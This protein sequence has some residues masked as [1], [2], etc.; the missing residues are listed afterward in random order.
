M[1]RASRSLISCSSKA[2]NNRC[3][4]QPSVSDCAHRSPANRLMVG[5]RKSV[6][7]IPR[8][9]EVVVTVVVVVDAVIDAVLIGPPQTARHKRPAL[10]ASRP[11]VAPL[12]LSLIHILRAHETRHDLVCRLLL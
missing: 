2:S 3:A 10:A 4:G 7:I 12:P 11:P 5:R 1:R 8:R 6:S 9:A